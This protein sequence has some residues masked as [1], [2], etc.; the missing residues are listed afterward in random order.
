MYKSPLQD[1][2]FL[3]AQT[4]AGNA[5]S[6]APTDPFGAMSRV[7]Q[8]YLAKQAFDGSQADAK[9]AKQA[10]R[11]TLAQFLQKMQPHEAI[12]QTATNALDEPHLSGNLMPETKTVPGDRN[13]AIGILTG[14]EDPELQRLGLAQMLKQEKPQKPTIVPPGSVVLGPNNQPVYSAPHKPTQEKA[15]G[16]R[17]FSLPNGLIQDQQFVGGQWQNV[18]APYSRR[19]NLK[20]IP[21]IGVIDR[22]TGA[23]TGPY[24]NIPGTQQASGQPA[25]QPAS[26]VPPRPPGMSPATYDQV[27]KK[28]LEDKAEERRSAPKVIRQTEDTI[29]MVKELV[30]H[31]GMKDTV[32]LPES[33]SGFFHKIG[34][35]AIPGTDAAD[36]IGRLDQIEG[37]NF[38]AAFEGLKG[39]GHITEIEGDRATKAISR[40]GATGLSEEE[41]RT[42]ANELIEIL[43]SGIADA[44]KKSGLRPDIPGPHLNVQETSAAN[45]RS[46]AS[47]TG[48]SDGL[49]PAE[50]K[51]LDTL[52]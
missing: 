35:G 44:Y 10:T 22:T 51:L 37:K 19:D 9:K 31:P 11:N 20:A 34:I 26:S 41:Y 42:A 6:T 17:E 52:R 49:T 28:D 15:P 14:S 4:L 16:S 8:A 32:G 29:R 1:P 27:L 46:A 7:F 36:F 3:M 45:N 24:G 13:A 12:D 38:L 21:G 5:G 48:G 47:D 23:V 18:G 39:G 30:A 2:R 25:A 33:V 40:L 50:R 43:H